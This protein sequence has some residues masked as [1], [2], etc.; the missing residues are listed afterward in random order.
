MN[1]SLQVF[2]NEQFG[3]V[4]TLDEDGK[5]YFCGA[6]AAKALGYKRPND[7]ISTH[8]KGTVKR[9][10]LTNGGVQE[11]LFIPEGDLYRLIAHSRLPAAEE[12]E[13]WV[14]DEVLP[15]IRRTGTYSLRS[16]PD[17]MS[18]MVE[19]LTRCVDGLSQCVDGLS[20]RITYLEQANTLPS[21]KRRMEPYPLSVTAQLLL[22]TLQGLDCYNIGEVQISNNQLLRLTNIGS[23]NTLLRARRELM[24][25]GYITVY[26]GI[27]GTPSVY[28]FKANS[29]L[30]LY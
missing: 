11:L 8:C 13:K 22:Q 26:P 3:S 17:Q 20:K 7:A 15:T 4:R 6:D 19:T 23:K 25:A 29:C 2:Q 28:R 10:T 14:F 24:D 27:K 16:G 9:R 18:R 12:F 30:S 1:N 21:P 5:V